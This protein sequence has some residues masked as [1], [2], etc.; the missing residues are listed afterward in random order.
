MAPFGV[1]WQDWKNAQ[2]T[3]SAATKPEKDQSAENSIYGISVV[4][5][6]KGQ[7]VLLCWFHNKLFWAQWP[8]CPGT[9]IPPTVMML[10][11]DYKN[12]LFVCVGGGGCGINHIWAPEWPQSVIKPEIPYFWEHFSALHSDKLIFIKIFE[13]HKKKQKYQNSYFG[14]G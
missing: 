2:L 13:Y 12:K 6:L 8:T 1:G 10:L 3:H 5:Y 14:K 11:N 7:Y 9:P 4:M